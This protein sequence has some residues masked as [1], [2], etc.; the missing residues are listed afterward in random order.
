MNNSPFDFSKMQGLLSGLMDNATKNQPIPPWWQIGIAE[1]IYGY[2][3]FLNCARS[4]LLK[5][6]IYF[7]K[8]TISDKYFYKFPEKKD[9]TKSG[10]EIIKETLS[11]LTTKILE[12]KEIKLVGILN[13]SYD[14]TGYFL[15]HPEAAFII[16]GGEDWYSIEIVS[17]N[18]EL[19]ENIKSVMIDFFASD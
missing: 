12:N 13:H 11:N 17:N 4:N 8:T 19:T 10:V 5:L 16:W 3:D 6:A 18:S 15:I 1:K 9:F 14:S 7:N 2:E